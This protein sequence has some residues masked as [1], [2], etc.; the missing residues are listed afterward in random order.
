MQVKSFRSFTF[1]TTLPLLLVT[2][3][4]GLGIPNAQASIL[5]CSPSGNYASLIALNSSGGCTMADLTFSNFQIA[6]SANGTGITPNVS[7]LSFVTDD[8]SINTTTGQAIYGF[9]FNPNLAVVGIGS[10]DILIQ[11][12][13]TSTTPDITSLH[14]QE[15]AYKSGD[16]TAATVTEGPDCG[17]TTLPSGCVFL[18]TLSV[19]TSSPSAEEQGLGPFE[20]IHVV[21]DINAV[22]LSHNGSV[23]I[24]NVRDAVDEHGP[25]K[26]GNT[27]EPGVSASLGVG[28]LLIGL[29][30]LSAG[31]AGRKH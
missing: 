12:D 7:Q 17:K 15:T 26:L 25:D 1:G 6:T 21:K 3:A 18:S 24:T 29:G 10:E 19:T 28:L 16:N 5:S 14:I 9:E 4:L 11:Y 31:R 30:K 22:S 2:L 8:P 23:F 20:F 13:I 27:P